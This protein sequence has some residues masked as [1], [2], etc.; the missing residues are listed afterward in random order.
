MRMRA[1]LSLTVGFLFVSCTTDRFERYHITADELPRPGSGVRI[2]YLGTSGFLL[3]S[4][5]ATVLVDPYFTRIGFVDYFTKPALPNEARINWAFERLPQRARRPDLV[6][7]THGHVDHALD[8]VHITKGSP[9]TLLAASRTTCF[10]AQSC[11]VPRE[12]TVALSYGDTRSFG[13]VRLHPSA[14]RCTDM[15]VRP[16]QILHC[17]NL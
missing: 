17:V 15:T 5:D 10:L 16:F 8:A 13:S 14:H 9:R 12:Q 6:L 1:F 2:T 4:R 3:E 11:G 7:V